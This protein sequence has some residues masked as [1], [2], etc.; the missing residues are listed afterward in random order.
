MTAPN[1]VA[2][3]TI[4]GKTDVSAAVGTTPV[5][6][7]TNATSSGQVYKV[8]FL[9]CSNLLSAAATVTVDLFRSSVAYTIAKDISIP[10][11]ATL[12][13]LNKGLYLEEGDALRVTSNTLSAFDV[14]CSYEVISET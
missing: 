9:T 12:D 3:A 2:V 8:N 13:L 5:A 4:T 11:G 7:A 14:V 1:V 6:I 10:A